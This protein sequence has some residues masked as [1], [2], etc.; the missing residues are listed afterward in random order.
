MNSQISSMLHTT[1]LN[2]QTLELPHLHSKRN[3][4]NGG[5]IS[6]I[7]NTEHGKNIK[8]REG[9]SRSAWKTNV[10]KRNVRKRNAWRENVRS[11]SARRRNIWRRSDESVNKR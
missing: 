7:V 4:R 1:R 11:K 6:K 8:V 10:G 9:R 5:Q 2:P 3:T